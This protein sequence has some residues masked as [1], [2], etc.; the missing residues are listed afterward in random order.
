MF[1]LSGA[2]RR[3]LS[4]LLIAGLLAIFCRPATAD[5]P[6]KRELRGVWIAT[7]ENIDWPSARNLTP[8]QQRREYIRMLDAQQRTGINAVFVQVRP[9][10]DAFYQSSLEPWSKWLTGTQG[11]APSPAYDPLPFMIEE[12]HARGM[13][14]HAWFNPYRGSTDTLTR[15][16]APLHPFRQHPE[17]FLRYSGKLLYNP[18]LPEVRQ[19]INRVILD[20]VRRY[21]IDGVHFDDYFYPY[22]EAGKVIQDEAAFARHNPDGLKLPDWRRQNVNILIRDLH[23]SIQSTKRWVKFGISPFGV[24]RNQATDPNGSATRA[25]QG[26]DGLYADALE[27]VRKGWVDYL[28][29]QLYWSSTFRLAQYPVLVEWWARNANGRHLYIGHGAYRM[30]ESTKAD[31]TWRNPREL[32]R[33]VRLNRTFPTE[34]G[35]SVFFSSKSLLANA[36]HTTDSLRQN[37][38]RYPALVPT[39]PWLDAVPPRPAQNLTLTAAL[40]ANTLTWQPSPI[41]SDGDLAA[42]YVLYRFEGDETPT[43]NDPR[44]ILA[45]IRPRTGTGL[46]F[47]DTTARPGQTYAYYLTAVDRLHNESR[48]V[49][50]RTTGRT[51][52]IILA[53]APAETPAATPTAPATPPATTSPVTVPA[54][55]PAAS[56]PVANRPAASAV[57][58]IKTKT[59]PKKKG[60]FR[61][62]FGG[63]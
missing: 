62:L 4:L 42:Y 54:P 29:P 15:R 40:P 44:R 1:S 51:G 19:Y 35:G 24:W 9:A 26:Y 36:L 58:K 47:T 23:D 3:V 28:L 20:V 14:F 7:V 41:A 11:K 60:F 38:F 56:P 5:V 31:T 22:P 6:P 25:F 30:S 50:V 27:W 32:P 43:P 46:A 2:G 16:L 21:D 59:K 48:P 55:R 52:E 53:Q 34:V 13:E 8:E 45:V 61:R 17:W 18:G 10:S 49:S 57:T 63:R 12:A 39:M 37:L 33:Q